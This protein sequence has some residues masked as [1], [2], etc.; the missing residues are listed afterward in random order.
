[1]KPNLIQA[2]FDGLSDEET[3]LLIA[4]LRRKTKRGPFTPR[5]F[6]ELTTEPVA[7]RTY[8]QA[9]IEGQQRHAAALQA[10][11]DALTAWA[12]AI[13]AL[14]AG[15]AEAAMQPHA[16]DGTQTLTPAFEARLARLEDDAAAT[17][18]GYDEIAALEVKARPHQPARRRHTVAFP[19]IGRIMQGGRPQ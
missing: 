3:Q 1:M 18:D 17:R 11:E 4:Q 16:V 5:Q 10:R 14:A 7:P 8:G 19:L 12:A 15:R 6:I 13:S 9:E 2:F